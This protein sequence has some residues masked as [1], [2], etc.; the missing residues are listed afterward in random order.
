M[1]SLARVRLGLAVLVFLAA[2]ALFY[3][4]AAQVGYNVDEGQAIW[5]SAYFRYVFL[6]GK[7][8][9]PTWDEN[10][11]TLTQTPVYR[12]II[13]ASIW[14]HGL[15]SQPLELEFRSD[16][17]RGPNR[18]RYLDPAIY[19]NERRLAEQRQVPRPSAEVLW[20]A[21]VPMVVLGAGAAAFLFLVAAELVGGWLGL[22]AG[23]VAT[24]GFVAAPFVQRLVPRAHTEA[25]FLCFLF[26]GLWLAILAARAAV[27]GPGNQPTVRRALVLGGLSGLAVGLSAGSKLTGVL[28]LAGLGGFAGGAL[29]L[30]LLARWCTL[31]AFIGPRVLLERAW[32][33]SA[34]GAVV[35]LLVFLAVNPFLWPNPVARTQAMLQF[36]VQEM[37]GQRTLN[38]EMA[39]PEGVANRL[40]LVT[41]HSVYDELWFGQRGYPP[42]EAV[43]AA[44]GAIA[45]VMRVLGGRQTG[46]LVSA[47]AVFGV[48]GLV[49]VVGSGLNLGIDWDRYYLPT[50][51]VGVVLAGM[52]AAALVEGGRRMVSRRRAPTTAA[53][54]PPPIPTASSGSAG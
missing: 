27:A 12:Y 49:L 40:W 47:E 19:R 43:L 10:Y 13:G 44:V 17:V 14:A 45:L 4:R 3:D 39:V 18:W 15:N 51:A 30:A 9:S 32:R 7:F 16:E 25:P 2:G 33:W 22:V 37:F 35:G 36:R 1:K 52:G 54:A 53:A 20:A 28:A 5:P 34:V 38:E 29:V 46:G 21:R 26:L 48:W 31:E 11:W 41:R 24:A 8:G 50:A 23:S 6:E 42:V